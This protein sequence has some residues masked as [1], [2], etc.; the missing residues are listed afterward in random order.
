[1]KATVAWAA[2]LG[3]LVL[4]SGCATGEK[5]TREEAFARHDRLPALAAALDEAEGQG[6]PDLAPDGF[7]AAS[8]AGDRALE[9][10][11]RGRAAEADAE[12]E[13]GLERLERARIDADR[14]REVLRDV[15]APRERARKA[16]AADLFAL[17][18]S[19]ADER[20]HDVARLVEQGR[21]DTARD[22]RVP[23]IDTYLALELDALKKGTD[24]AA[25]AA[26]ERAEAAGARDRAPKTFRKAREELEVARSVLEADRQETERADQ[27][28]R[29]AIWLAARATRIA[30]Q[31][32]DFDR[33]DYSGEDL[34]LW[35]QDQ[36]AA[37]AAPL[38]AELPFDTPDLQVVQGL[39][40]DVRALVDDRAAL[41]RR[42]AETESRYEAALSAE[43]SERQEMAR[44]ERE[45]Q[46]RFDRIQALF[47][48]KEA[49]V[50]RQRQNVLIAAH[51]FWFPSGQ[52]EIEAVNFPLLTKIVKAIREFPGARVGVMGHTDAAGDDAL[53]KSLS[54]ARADKVAK[55]LVDVGGM[56]PDR[57][58]SNGFGEERPVATNDTP[59]GRAAN[60]RVE[61]LI[62]NE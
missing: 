31:V 55:F 6:V 34:V 45:T 62:L 35:H 24:R 58:Q 61:V 56:D 59:E 2:L 7:A 10:A 23:L 27:H 54:Q 29:R 53:N 18:M 14:A 9:A 32:K 1:M 52:S 4:A 22:R 40:A 5:L 20:L 28:A 8:E 13:R 36:L 33:L 42:L 39:A 38:G 11:V 51:G 19:A 37:V 16:G 41:A 48:P 21:E 47:S 46:E 3:G 12:A 57:V 43:S 60:R 49:D 26:I 44:R 17:R 25:E 50:F 15:L 30:E